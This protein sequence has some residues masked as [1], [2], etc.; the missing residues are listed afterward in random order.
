MQVRSLKDRGTGTLLFQDILAVIPSHWVNDAYAGAATM[1]TAMPS[2][3]AWPR[4]SR[5]LPRMTQAFEKLMRQ[6]QPEGRYEKLDHQS[7]TYEKSYEMLSLIELTPRATRAK[8]K[9]G[10]NHPVEKRRAIVEQLRKR[11]RA[12]DLRAVEEVERWIARH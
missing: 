4:S 7:P 12:G 1:I 11:G 6:H 2:S 3:T 9:L 10:Q 5:S 8:W